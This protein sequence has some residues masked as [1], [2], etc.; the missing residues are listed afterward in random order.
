VPL[1]FFF[2]GLALLIV[3]AEVLVRGATRLGAAFG[4]PPI[5]IGLTIVAFGTSAPEVAVAV[6]AVLAGQPDLAV[7]NV[8]GS[9]IANILFVLGLAAL[10]T[11]LIV[12]QR[13]VQIDVPLVIGASFLMLFMALDGAISRLD[14][15]V[16]L[17]GGAAYTI[18]TVSQSRDPT[19]AV[20]AEYAGEF[21]AIRAGP[22]TWLVSGA[23]VLA[24]VGLLA[25]GAHWLVLGAVSITTALGVSELVIGLTVVAVGTSMPEAVTSV[26]A[27]LRGERNIAVGS[28]VGSNLLNIFWVLGLASTIASG[29]VSVSPAALRLDIPVMIAVAIACMPMFLRGNVIARWEGAFFLGYF[30]AYTAYLILDASQHRVL[31]A[32][33]AVMLEF[34]LPLTAVTLVV[35]LVGA[36]RAARAPRRNP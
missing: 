33:S 29:G 31:P 13:L 24:G 8:V 21:G 27:A 23:Q 3:G 25:L 17:A 14:G 35:I 15:L 10:A 20:R 22:G 6:Q 18:W 32:F 1:L 4:M 2:V 7:G 12:T 9:N 16:L 36:V 34:V 30:V 5:V 19:Q 11:P 26:V 28:I